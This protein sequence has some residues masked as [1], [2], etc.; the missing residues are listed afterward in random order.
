METLEKVLLMAV[1]VLIF[2]SFLYWVIP[3]L[4]IINEYK[5]DNDTPIWDQTPKD[6]T[7][8]YGEYFIYDI[9][10]SDISGIDHYLV[11][12]TSN[13]YINPVGLIV[14][15]KVLNVGEYWIEI[16]AY[17]PSDNYISAEIKITV[18]N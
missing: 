2:S 17:D 11:N 9:N 8:K 13:F 7:I 4:A 16:R 5:E 6:Q 12:D 18:Y 1:G 15:I 10:A 3:N 14:S